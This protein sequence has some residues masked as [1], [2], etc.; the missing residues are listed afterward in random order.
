MKKVILAVIA[1]LGVTAAH[2]PALGTSIGRTSRVRGQPALRKVLL[3]LGALG[4]AGCMQQRMNNGLQ[5]L[6]GQNIQ[7]AVAEL[8][9]PDTQRT[10]FGDTIYIWSAS[11]PGGAIALQTSPTMTAF[12]PLRAN[13]TIQI[14]TAPD[15]TIKQGSWRGNQAGCQPYMSQLAQ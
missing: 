6:V 5:A 9:Y 1:V 13:C 2:F 11:G 8:G 4:L 7:V 10:M 14:A 12:M 3:M 15:G